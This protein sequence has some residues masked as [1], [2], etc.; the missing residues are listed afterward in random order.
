MR[1]SCASLSLPQYSPPADAVLVAQHLLKLGAHLVT[2]LA[3][4]HVHNLAR[5][6]RLEAKSTLEK[7][8]GEERKNARNSVKQ[9]GTGNRKFWW[10]VRVCPEQQ[11]KLFFQS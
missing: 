1:P 3:R 2:S 11:K 4:V 10:H 9:F 8:G 5:R 6:S 7:K